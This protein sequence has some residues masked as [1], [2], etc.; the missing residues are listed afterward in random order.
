MGDF[1]QEQQDEMEAIE[2]IYSEEIDILDTSPHRFTIPVKTD[3]YDEDEGLGRM[4]LLKFSFTKTYPNEAPLVE[5]EESENMEEDGILDDMA[6]HIKEQI[7]ENLGMPMIFTI[8]SAMIEWL[9]ETNDRLK[10]EAEE[11]AQRIKDAADEEER[12]KLEGTKVTIESF[13]AWKADFDKERM[14][15]MLVKEKTGKEKL[16]GRELFM[17]DTTLNESDLKFLAEAGDTAVTVDESLFE[18]L[19]DLDIDDDSDED[20]NPGD[21]DSD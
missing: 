21:D 19:E 6:A 5:V 15:K 11:E 10:R 9:G 3:D 4:V 14:E 1:L 17:T 20:W 12:K 7:E 2:S 13:L 18:D 16:T 8:I